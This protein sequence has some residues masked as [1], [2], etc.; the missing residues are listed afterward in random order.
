MQRRASPTLVVACALLMA[1]PS[2]MTA[3]DGGLTVDTL[4]FRLSLAFVVSYVGIR[5]LTR[6]VAGYAAP[7]YYPPADAERR[8]RDED[9]RA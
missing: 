4:C 9:A 1:A 8:S 6:I 3:L 7:R 2:I 5:T